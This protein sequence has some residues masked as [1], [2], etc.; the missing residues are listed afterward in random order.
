VFELIEGKEL[1]RNLVEDGRGFWHGNIL[2]FLYVVRCT[3]MAREHCNW[4]S[5]NSLF[6]RIFCAFR[7]SIQVWRK[8]RKK[9]RRS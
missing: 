1:V 3:C 5:R 8:R 2:R 4:S 7:V 9:W 6:L